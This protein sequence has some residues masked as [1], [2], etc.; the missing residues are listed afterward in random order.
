VQG[1]ARVTLQGTEVKPLDD[2]VRAIGA[3]PDDDEIEVTLLLKHVDPPSREALERASVQRLMS[4]QYADRFSA[5]P[6]SVA[7]IRAFA[8]ANHL[9]VVDADLIKRRVILSGTA[10]ALAAAFGTRLN[11]YAMART[12]KTFHSTATPPSVPADLAPDLQAV[13]GLDTRPIVKPHFIVNHA[14]AGQTAFEVPKVASLYNFP[15]DVNGTGQTIA[16]LQFGGGFVQSDLDSYFPSIGLRSPKVTVVS[17]DKVKNAPGG[18]S[19]EEVALDIEVAGAT[20]NGADIIVYFAPN[21]GRGFVDAITEAIHAPQPPTVL[22]ISWG[23]AEDE[24]SQQT[25]DALNSVLHDAGALG[26]TVVVATGDN[27]SSDGV[28]D[29]LLHVDFPSSSPYVLAVGGTTLTSQADK[30]A[31]EETWNSNNHSNAT[32]GGISAKMP[33]PGY[34]DSFNVPAHPRTGFVGRGIPDVA[35]DANPSTGYRIQ[36]HGN[37]WSVGG[38]SAAAPLWAGLI[39]LLNQKLGHSLGFVNEKLYQLGPQVFHNITTGNNDSTGL[40]SYSAR[41]GWNACTGLGTPDAQKLLA[42]LA[43]ARQSAPAGPERSLRVS[44]GDQVGVVQVTYGILDDL[45][46]GC[47]LDPCWMLDASSYGLKFFF[48]NDK[49]K[50]LNEIR[51]DWPFDGT[52]EGVHIGDSYNSVVANLGQPNSSFY[53]GDTPAYLFR[54]NGHLLRCDLDASRKCATIFYYDKW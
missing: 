44:F 15:T 33:R 6:D 36:V 3:V 26:I 5:R 2:D 46:N 24:F 21:S 1:N 29:N 31:S 30:I 34:Q 54:V 4:L 19:D 16:I 17:V 20:A 32:G 7:R 27:G 42:S 28:D 38:T 22:S 13:L 8:E 45:T 10:A 51:A 39:A 50:V 14:T 23:S 35:A 48:T 9:K 25:I 47:G 49:D 53:F 12:G 18:D 40:G 37:S 52:I 43:P 41:E 11:A